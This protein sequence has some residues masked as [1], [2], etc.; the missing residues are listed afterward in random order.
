M[1]QSSQ[2]DRK[3]HVHVHVHVHQDHECSSS[4]HDDSQHSDSHIE[5]DEIAPEIIK[6]WKLA[7]EKVYNSK[8][9]LLKQQLTKAKSQII[10]IE[11]DFTY[12]EVV[13]VND[14]VYSLTIAANMTKSTSPISLLFALR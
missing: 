9:E 14:D 5:L 1:R 6:K 7:E 3:K 8:N 11:D 4:E 13:K 10:I 12:N 2:E